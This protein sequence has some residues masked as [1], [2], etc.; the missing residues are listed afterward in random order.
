MPAQARPGLVICVGVRPLRFLS[1]TR[2]SGPRTGSS[3]RSHRSSSSLSSRIDSRRSG[4]HDIRSPKR[5]FGRAAVVRYFPCR[6]H[7]RSTSSRPRFPPHLGRFHDSDTYFALRHLPPLHWLMQTLHWPVTM[8]TRQP[9]TPVPL[10]FADFASKLAWYAPFQVLLYLRQ[11]F[12][13]DGW[14]N[15]RFYGAA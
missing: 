3:L 7:R 1:N 13:R 12:H 10:C 4:S 6:T 2:R 14:Y 15:Q 11:A 8:T 9:P 5:L